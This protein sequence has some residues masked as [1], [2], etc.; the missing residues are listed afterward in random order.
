MARCNKISLHNHFVR[1]LPSNNCVLYQGYCLHSFGLS[2]PQ[3]LLN[4]VLPYC[5]IPTGRRLH[6]FQGKQ[7][8][9]CQ[10]RGPSDYH[11][12]WVLRPQL[13]AGGLSASELV[14]WYGADRSNHCLF[15]VIETGIQGKPVTLRLRLILVT[16]A[17]SQSHTDLSP[18][19]RGSLWIKKS[20]TNFHCPPPIWITKIENRECHFFYPLCDQYFNRDFRE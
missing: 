16:W 9:V 12:S 6:Y 3:V 14:W 17:H 5:H 20:G 7:V 11:A 1:S 8:R 18:V 19:G 4:R 13:E 15:T 10:A 2:A